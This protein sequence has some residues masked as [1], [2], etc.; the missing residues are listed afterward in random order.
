MTLILSQTKFEASSPK[1]IGG[2]A[3]LVEVIGRVK[4]QALVAYASCVSCSSTKSS[5]SR[6]LDRTAEGLT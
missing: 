6:L 2:D 4:F 1:D 5:K 3:F